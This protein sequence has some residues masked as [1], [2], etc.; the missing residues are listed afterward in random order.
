MVWPFVSLRRVRRICLQMNTSSFQ[1]IYHFGFLFKFMLKTIHRERLKPLMFLVHIR[2]FTFPPSLVFVMLSG[3]QKTM[4]FTTGSVMRMR[5]IFVSTSARMYS[6]GANDIHSSWSSYRLCPA[7]NAL[8]L[9]HIRFQFLQPTQPARTQIR[10][11]VCSVHSVLT[12]A[13]DI[14]VRVRNEIVVHNGSNVEYQL[15]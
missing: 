11:R 2:N 7:P 12:T 15:R 5:V 13:P 14:D 8:R 9:V 3:H 1:L 6:F 4:N 10:I